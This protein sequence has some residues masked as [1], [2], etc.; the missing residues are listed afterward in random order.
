MIKAFISE[1][2]VSKQGEGPYTGVE[3]IFIRFA[4]CSLNCAYCDT[5]TTVFTEYTVE[6]LLKK[7]LFFKEEVDSVSITGGE[8][9]EQIDF[10]RLWKPKSTI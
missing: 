6:E 4:G 1:V 5:D 3:Q 7:V 9:L 10:L 2:F 8:P